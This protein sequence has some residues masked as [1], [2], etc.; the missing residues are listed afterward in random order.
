MFYLKKF[1]TRM[2]SSDRMTINLCRPSY[3]IR[4]ASVIPFHKIICLTELFPD[5]GVEFV[6]K[7]EILIQKMTF[8]FYRIAPQSSIVVLPDEL[9]RRQAAVEE[10]LRVTRDAD[11]FNERIESSK[12]RKIREEVA[13]LR[14]LRVVRIET[15][16]RAAF[17]GIYGFDFNDPV[18][19]MKREGQNM[20]IEYRAALGPSAEP[21]PNPWMMG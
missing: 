7:G 5:Q 19:G 12:N 2:Q 18:I 10:W 15:R 11:A 21:L 16:G 3:P 14:D 20:N 9:A 1:R 13:R 6:W 17:P 4:Q 8:L